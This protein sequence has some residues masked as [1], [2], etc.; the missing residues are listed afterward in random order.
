MNIY[1]T[2]LN[3]LLVESESDNYFLSFQV[4]LTDCDNNARRLTT[5]YSPETVKVV[6][7][8]GLKWFNG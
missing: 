7:L 3:E 1:Y 8:E 5:I 6:A 2:F 4:S